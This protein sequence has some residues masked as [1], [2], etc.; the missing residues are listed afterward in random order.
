M[1]GNHKCH[2][3]GLIVAAVA[4]VGVTGCVGASTGV[5]LLQCGSGVPPRG[6]KPSALLLNSPLGILPCWVVPSQASNKRRLPGEHVS[7]RN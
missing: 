4:A 2:I 3:A 1:K 7:D 6:A 5:E